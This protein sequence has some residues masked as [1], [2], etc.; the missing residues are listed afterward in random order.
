MKVPSLQEAY[1]LHNAS[2]L[3]KHK[4]LLAQNKAAARAILESALQVPT[5]TKV[6]KQY[7]LA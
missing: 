7:E 1:S 2:T 3:Y 6:K 5:V 4:Q